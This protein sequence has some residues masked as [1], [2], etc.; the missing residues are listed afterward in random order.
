MNGPDPE[1][2]RSILAGNRYMVLATADASGTPWASPVWFAVAGHRE[3]YWVSSPE[4]THSRNIAARPEVGLVVFDSS[5]P[6]GAG[7]AVYMPARAE[8]VGPD[9]VERGVAVFNERSAAEGGWIIAPGDVAE[10][11]PFRLYRAIASAHSML[12]KDG[13][14]DHRVPIDI[15]G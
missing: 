3:F 8:V 9:T 13:T 15:D 10:G 7:Q 12:A 11:A 2:A 5:V 14:P 1:L 4:A 6:T